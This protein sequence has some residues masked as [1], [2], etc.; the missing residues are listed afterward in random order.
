MINIKSGLIFNILGNDGSVLE[1][2]PL[3]Q[4]DILVSENIE[5][6]ESEENLKCQEEPL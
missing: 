5:N 3:F 6:N 1:R 2:N 4:N